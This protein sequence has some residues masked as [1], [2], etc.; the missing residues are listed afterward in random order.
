[1]KQAGTDSTRCSAKVKMSDGV[2]PLAHF[3]LLVWFLVK[4][5]DK[6]YLPCT[7]PNRR[8]T[9]RSQS[10]DPPTKINIDECCYRILTVT[11]MVK[12]SPPFFS[13]ELKFT[14]AVTE[15]PIH[16]FPLCVTD[17]YTS[18]CFI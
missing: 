8:I 4:R 9:T 17:Q 13:W 14:T 12:E 10:I 5:W 15:Y 6:L 7:S 3:T 18:S 2:T 11:Q 16:N 1:M